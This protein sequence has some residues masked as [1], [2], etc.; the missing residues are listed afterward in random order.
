MLKVQ[1]P[2]PP[3]EHNGVGPRLS[4]SKPASVQPSTALS[5]SIK[6]KLSIKGVAWSE[7]GPALSE[8]GV[9]DDLVRRNNLIELFVSALRESLDCDANRIRVTDIKT[10]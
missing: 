10:Q 5:S 2:T 9:E 1:P 8:P 4:L 6:C 7:L 3:L